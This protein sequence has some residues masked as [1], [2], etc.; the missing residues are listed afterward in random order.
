MASELTEIRWQEFLKREQ[1]VRDELARRSEG[2]LELANLQL[3]AA[4]GAR[5]YSKRK[6]I[7][8]LRKAA[9]TFEGAIAPMAACRAN[10][11][12][13]CHVPVMLL[14]SEAQVI[15]REIGRV[16]RDVPVERRDQAP[17][18]WRGTGHACQFLINDHC[19]IY[20]SRPIAC[21]LLFNLD[22]DALL[23]QHQESPTLVPYA[24][25][26]T[27]QLQAAAAASQNDYVAD[28][29]EFFA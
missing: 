18:S 13:C 7:A 24:D 9:A 26:R 16:P 12:A 19:S 11:S 27:F 17:P 6:V 4:A 1:A 2:V 15:G 5:M 23:C 21:R 20:A 29:G 22:R 14:A 8:W 25:T 28:L 10:C 3:R